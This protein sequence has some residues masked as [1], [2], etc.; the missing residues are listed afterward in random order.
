MLTPTKGRGSRK[1]SALWPQV[2]V[3]L[4]PSLHRALMDHLADPLI[5]ITPR[6][7]LAA[8]FERAIRN[9]LAARGVTPCNTLEPGT[10]T[11]SLSSPE[12]LQLPDF[13]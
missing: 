11:E 13:F 12:T 7:A 2:N 9:E 6:G 10:S 1:V 5:T 3:R 8:F 4:E